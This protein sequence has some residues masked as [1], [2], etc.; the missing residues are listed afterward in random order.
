M[1]HGCIVENFSNLIALSEHEKAILAHFE[2][3][4]RAVKRHESLWHFREHT[5]TLYTLQDGWA[6]AYKI[7]LMGEMKVVEIFTPGDIIGLRDF[8]FGRHL[9]D[10]RMMTDGTVCAFPYRYILEACQQSRALSAAFFA[11]ASRD[12]ALMTERVTSLMHCSA[13]MKI[14]H[15]IIEMYLRLKHTHPDLGLRFEFPLN[16]KLMASLLGLTSVH[17]S[18]MLGELAQEGMVKK[19]RRTLEILDYKRLYREAQ[20]DETYIQLDLS[21]MLEID[22]NDDEAPMG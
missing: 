20:F 5:Q 9:T 6:Y 10:V 2:K 22:S 21:H 16:Q 7:S 4:A 8:T 14:A 19:Q 3:D 11:T 12:Q 13:R 17:V 15:F 18:R 1:S